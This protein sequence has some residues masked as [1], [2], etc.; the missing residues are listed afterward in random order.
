[1]R[2]YEAFGEAGFHSAF[3]TTY[4]FNA[5][6]F[7]DIPL[8]RLRGAG[9]RN[10]A[11]LVDRDMANLDAAEYGPPQ[12]AGTLYHLIPVQAQAAFH[13][14][15]TLLLGTTKGKL[16][17][18]SANLTALGLAGN[19]ELVT[20]LTYDNQADGDV[21]P[22]LA[23]VRYIR[24][25]VPKD[26]P[27]FE[28]A[29]ERAVL[30]CPWLADVN[31][32]SPAESDGLR[33]IHDQPQQTI[34]D[35]IIELVGA[36]PV[37]KLIVM[38]PYWDEGLEGLVQLRR[39]LGNPDTHILA[40]EGAP[41]PV[42]ALGR[43]PGAK[44]FDLKPLNS[45]KFLGSRFLHAK[46]FV[47]EG[48]SWDHVISGSMNCSYA[49]LLGRSF[50]QGNAEAGIY[51]RV[52]AATAIEALD[53]VGYE[54]TPLA[55]DG[56]VQQTNGDAKRVEAHFR[57]DGGRL[58]LEGRRLTWT[59][60]QTSMHWAVRI[61]MFDQDDQ[62][63]FQEATE[64]L[65]L[66]PWMIE[67]DD[68]RL[69]YGIAHFADGTISAPVPVIDLDT[70][71]ITTSTVQ[72]GRRRKLMESLEGVDT[73][74][75]DLVEVL[76]KLLELDHDDEEATG[77]LLRRTRDDP[78][79]ND[80]ED[81]KPGSQILSYEEFVRARALARKADITDAFGYN[82]L[83]T[84]ASLMSDCLNRMIGLMRS[85]LGVAAEAEF[86][87]QRAL[88]VAFMESNGGDAPGPLPPEPPKP[89]G[90]T[91]GQREARKQKTENAEK[92]REMVSAFQTRCNR[93]TGAPITT[94]E[95]VRARLILQVILDHAQPTSGPTR[96]S[97]LLPA[98]TEETYDWPRLV[99]RAV[100]SFQ[101]L[102][103]M[104]QLQI[105][106]GNHDQRLVLEYLAIV[107]V[108]ATVTEQAIGSLKPVGWH[109]ALQTLF[110]VAR[111]QAEAVLAVNPEDRVYFD[112]HY[113][114]YDRRYR[115]LIGNEAFAGF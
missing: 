27:G 87:R 71:A 34:L 72:P 70:L 89:D 54:A 42:R 84:G 20:T 15:I 64:A 79:D 68:F 13:P 105:E 85:D 97:D 44:L 47:A 43:V 10:I 92:I 53:L 11:V 103:M 102:D 19:K 93:L 90:A 67:R 76:N 96:A 36:D 104:H 69:R 107:I 100:K 8:P 3:L 109:K 94:S 18:G 115:R 7:E 21:T 55:T 35:Q 17:V 29:L 101:K 63:L 48:K 112:N 82:R 51:K 31:Q 40:S 75:P 65:P 60:V 14:K 56:L 80:G 99:G 23:A 95:V 113:E 83:E 98:F 106:N 52:A 59:Q 6:A 49:G 41:F 30:R 66:G 5:Q 108:T 22:F 46:L 58:V 114:K 12:F 111:L 4:A 28:M 38:S 88:D 16:M 1:M 74:G 62:H 39:E 81:A 25:Y 91:G 57:Q 73:A 77:A 50:S 86:D 32:A 78:R 33:L 9:C 24:D 45:R 2:Y 26:F 37:R 61:D 110:E